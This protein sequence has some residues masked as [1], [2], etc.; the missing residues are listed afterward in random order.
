VV[1]S[2]SRLLDESLLKL[3]H[4]LTPMLTDWGVEDSDVMIHSLGVTFWTLL[5]DR[6]DYAAVAEVP[7]PSKGSFAYLGD[8]VRSDSGWFNRQ[9]GENE[10]LVE[11]ERFTN[12][13]QDETKLRSKMQNLLLAHRRWGDAP[14][15]LV[16]AYWT[17]S[18]V[19]MPQH[20]AFNSLL[21]QGFTLAVTNERIPGTL[22]TSFHCFQFLLQPERN[23]LLKLTEIIRRF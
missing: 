20:S 3:P 9:T 6:L 7:A 2:F 11:F 16:L 5:G 18:L 10:V 4:E 8:K 19:N 1:D 21:R 17:K 15:H 13:Q 22:N 14:R 12:I 23:G